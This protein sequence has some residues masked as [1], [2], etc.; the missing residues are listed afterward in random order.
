MHLAVGQSYPETGGE[1]TSAIHWDLIA[2][3]RDGGLLTADG[4]TI[5]EN[6]E[7]V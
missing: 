1:N 5:V 3:L 7:L 6:G 2:D 4:E